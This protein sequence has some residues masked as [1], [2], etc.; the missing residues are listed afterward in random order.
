MRRPDRQG[1]LDPVDDL[2]GRLL[3]AG[4]LDRLIPA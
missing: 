2:D 4:R 3:R 1:T